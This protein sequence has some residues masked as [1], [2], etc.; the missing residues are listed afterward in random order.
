MKRFVATTA[1]AG[2]ILGGA[3]AGPAQAAP[4]P[5][6]AAAQVSY[7][8]PPVAWGAC[9]S[10]GLQRRGAECGF[11]QVPLDYAH[12]H[13]TTIKLAVSRIRHKTPDAQYQGVM[14]VNPGGPGGSGLTLSVLGEY[15]PNGAGEAYDWIGFDP[16]GVGSS[17]PSLSCDGDYFAHN[18]P[19]YVPATPNLEKTWLARSKG[20]A[21]AC[22]AAGGDLL[23]H[24]KTTDSARD[25][26]SIR[27]V[28]GRDQINYYG[29]SYGTYLG[30]VYATLFP[31][32]VRRMVLDG[33]VDPRKVW[34]QANL[35]QDVA[36]DRNIKLYFDWVAKHDDVYHLGR[37]GRAVERL[38][39]AQQ[40]KLLKKPAG[41]VIGPDEWSDIFLQAG[42]YVFGWADVAKAFAGWVHD[43]DWQTLQA[44]Y[45]SS[46]PQGPGTDNGFAVY[47][48]VQ[49][50][51]VQ[52]PTNWNRW[53]AD[54][55]RTFAKAPFE[56]WGNAWFNAPCI[57]WDGQVGKPVK[58]DG[59]KVGGVLLIS[60]T[61]DAATPYSGSLEVRSRFPKAVLVEGVGGTT[62]AGSL[63]GVACV[64]DTIAAYLATG[65][66]PQRVGGRRS[67]VQCDPVPQ[68]DPAASARSAAP[69]LAPADTER[70]EL[71]RLIG[72]R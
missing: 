8:P 72:V 49:C 4:G 57:W 18:R 15:V 59:R 63:N 21:K 16:R 12:P 66:L 11:V 31:Q 1:T 44:L 45:D 30:Q 9:E 53:R 3:V 37:T 65:A 14:L 69:S 67:D 40:L 54:N 32:R 38:F 36:F 26:D 29:F 48:G 70:S 22:A 64:D 50:T 25:M 13:G 17:Q 28:L 41:G 34:Y 23:D 47:L 20:Y 68:P 62:H 33:N 52:W 42:Y 71:R 35:D 56:T 2:L 60:E 51:D 10:P 55:W 27:K 6:P 61:L 46:N 5:R 39:Y 58:I 24:L 7:T 43:G 19:F